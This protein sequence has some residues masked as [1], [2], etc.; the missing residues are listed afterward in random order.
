MHRDVALVGNA[1]KSHASL[2]YDSHWPGEAGTISGALP[3][4]QDVIRYLAGAGLGVPA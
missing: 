3:G 4:R 2:P 1:R